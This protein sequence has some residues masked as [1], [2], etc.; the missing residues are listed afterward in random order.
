[1]DKIILYSTNCPKCKVIAKKLSL[2]NIEFTE[3]DCKADQTYISMLSGKGFSSMP[4]LQVGER[5][6]DFSKANK[7]I[8]EQ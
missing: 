4:V 7:W 3:L 1:M 2:K 6:F 8:G 5:F